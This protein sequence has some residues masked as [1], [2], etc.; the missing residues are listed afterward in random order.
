MSKDA[1]LLNQ[2][3]ESLESPVL[4]FFDWRRPAITIGYGQPRN[5][6]DFEKIAS[7][8]IGF[9]VRPTGGRAVLHWNE[10]TYSVVIPKGNPINDLSVTESYRVISEAL[11]GGLKKVGLDIE[12]SRGEIGGHRNPSCFSATSKFEITCN[13]R[14]LVGSAQ[15]R[16]KGAILQQ[17]SIPMDS[18]FRRL[19]EFFSDKS[20]GHDLVYKSTCV[21]ECLKSDIDKEQLIENIILA[22]SEIFMCEFSSFEEV[23]AGKATLKAEMP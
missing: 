11:A 19:P 21:E 12:L 8:N 2:A 4:R 10:L 1:R 17:G 20:I 14:K 9:A 23:L 18:N 16:K 6:I 3:I 13:G 15:R 22:F 5:D 7:E